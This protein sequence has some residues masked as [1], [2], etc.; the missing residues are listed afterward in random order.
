MSSEDNR[1]ISPDNRPGTL[2]KLSVALGEPGSV[3]NIA[4]PQVLF[5]PTGFPTC[6]ADLR[7][8][9]ARCF[10]LVPHARYRLER[11]RG[12]SS[13]PAVANRVGTATFNGWRGP[14][15][16]KG[17]DVLTL[18]NRAGRALTSLHVAHLRV[19]IVGQQ[20]VVASGTC[21]PG[22]Y[23]GRALSTPPASL[24]FGLG[25][26]GSGT[27]CPVKGSVAGL[28]TA[29]IAQTDDRSGGQ[30]VTEV[31][32][33]VRTTPIDGETLYGSFIALAKTGLGGRHGA[34]NSTGASVAVTIT[35]AARKVFHADNVNT[36]SGAVVTAL[37][38]GAYTA[39]WVLTDLN[40][41]TRTV[42][43]QFVEAP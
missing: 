8:Q 9:T 39:T 12:S 14:R 25:I 37:T 10:G 19:D 34:V 18:S 4:N 3:S 43:T 29:H 7:A 23:Y 22:D 36:A 26:G 40:G 42:R 15:P 32:N 28:S 21:E 33:I 35:S 27:I 20:T 2:V 1:A 31:S 5:T 13:V 24:G 11:A 6:T 41:D 16:I 30:T 17:G 38:P